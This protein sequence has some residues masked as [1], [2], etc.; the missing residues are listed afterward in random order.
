MATNG[1][2]FAKTA[3]LNPDFH[4]HMIITESRRAVGHYGAESSL[5]EEDARESFEW[6][7]EFLYPVREYFAK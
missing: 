7:E 6:A 1:R 3:I 5:T 4:R 2:E